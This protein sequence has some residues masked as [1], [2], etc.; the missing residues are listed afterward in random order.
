MEDLGVLYG[1]V[2]GRDEFG[3]LY[4]IVLG[5]APS[6]GVLGSPASLLG[7]RLRSEGEII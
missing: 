4:G 2:L 3:V 7:V 1:I 6:E 5:I